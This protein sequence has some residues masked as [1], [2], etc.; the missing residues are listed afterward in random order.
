MVRVLKD[1]RAAVSSFMPV[2]VFVDARV[3]E[4]TTEGPLVG[5]VI[6]VLCR[7]ATPLDGDVGADG[8]GGLTHLWEPVGE[9][10]EVGA[11]E[12]GMMVPSRGT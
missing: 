11:D 1:S 9:E 8:E 4:E 6:M 2:E 3:L 5:M 12:G 7:G 10:G